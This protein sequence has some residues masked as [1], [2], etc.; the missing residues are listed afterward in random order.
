MSQITKIKKD[1]LGLYV[2]AGGWICRPFFGTMFIEGDKVKSH[3]FGGS[4]KAGVTILTENFKRNGNYEYWSTTG[5]LEYEY[6][7]LSKKEITEK[8]N[9]YKNNADKV[10]YN[11][12]NKKFKE[13]FINKK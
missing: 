11:S 13:M 12:L 2:I 8:F 9:W 7:E 10:V 1:F 5:T 3:H 4:T 6:S